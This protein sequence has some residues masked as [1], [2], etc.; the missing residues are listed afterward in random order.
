MFLNLLFILFFLAF[1]QANSNDV[2]FMGVHEGLQVFM[3][4]D[5]EASNVRIPQ[6]NENLNRNNAFSTSTYLKFVPPQ[7]DFKER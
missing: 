4:K 6:V 1:I 2:Q 7:L 5:I 3:H